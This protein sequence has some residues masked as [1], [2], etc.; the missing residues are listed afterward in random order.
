MNWDAIGAVGEMPA[1]LGV[2]ITLGGAA[3][4]KTRDER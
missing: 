3:R 1:A 4:E 2:L